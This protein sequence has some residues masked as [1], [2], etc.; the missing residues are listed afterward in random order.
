MY[1]MCSTVQTDNKPGNIIIHSIYICIIIL[2]SIAI[3]RLNAKWQQVHRHL[4]LCGQ[5]GR[6]TEAG[7]VEMFVSDVQRR[8]PPEMQVFH[9]GNC[10]LCVESIV[11]HYTAFHQRQ[12]IKQPTMQLRATA[13]LC[14]IIVSPAAVK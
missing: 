11:P 1:F 5:A 6:V 9:D 13:T 3:Q 2:Y 10:D 8:K 12:L 4:V 7:E 14:N